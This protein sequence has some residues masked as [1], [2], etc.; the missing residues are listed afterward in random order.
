VI[1]TDR[2]SQQA[3]A[4][5]GTDFSVG[6]IEYTLT[7]SADIAALN[8]TDPS[9]DYVIFKGGSDEIAGSILLA[10]GMFT[11]PML[12][13]VYTDNADQGGTEGQIVI[14]K[15]N[16]IFLNGQKGN[17]SY[18]GT[19]T[20]PVKTF[21]KAM[22]IYN[23]NPG[24]YDG[25]YISGTVDITGNEIWDGGTDGVTIYR[26]PAEPSDRNHN[27]Y[28]RYPESGIFYTSNNNYNVPY[29]V[30]LSGQNGKL[31]LKN[32]TID[33]NRSIAK[34][35]QSATM[36]SVV[37]GATLNI[38][39][40][41]V[42]Q[43][44]DVW[45]SSSIYGGAVNANKSTV[46]MSGGAIRNNKASGGGG[47]YISGSTFNMSGGEITGNTASNTSNAY[48]SNGGGIFVVSSSSTGSVMN[49]SGGTISNNEAGYF[50]GGISVGGYYTTTVQGRNTFN[51]SGGVIAGNKSG[52]SGGG[53]FIQQNCVGSITGNTTDVVITDN[54][55]CLKHASNNLF[56]GGGIYVNGG[57]IM[58]GYPDG[59][60][61][62]YNVVI[63]D[64]TAA[65]EGGGI[66][67]CPTSHNKSYLG[68]GGI[69][70]GNNAPVA[71][72]FFAASGQYGS[73]SGIAHVYLSPFVLGGGV[74]LWETEDNEPVNYKQIQSQNPIRLHNDL[75][76]GDEAVINAESLAKVWITN[77]YSVNRGGGL[78]SNGIIYIGNSEEETINISAQK[79]WSD[80]TEPTSSVRLMLQ[81]RNSIDP[82]EFETVAY[83]IITAANNWKFTFENLPKYLDSENQQ[84]ITYRVIEDPDYVVE[85]EEG[86]RTVQKKCSQIFDSTAVYDPVTETWKITNRKYQAK[87][88]IRKTNDAGYEGEDTVYLM[89]A[90]FELKDGEGI[91]IDGLQVSDEN[92]F[93]TSEDGLTLSVG[94][95]Y[96]LKEILAPERCVPIDGNI[97]ITV[98]EPPEVTVTVQHEKVLCDVIRD[99]ET[100]VFTIYVPNEEMVDPEGIDISVEKIWD[101]NADADHIRPETIT[102]H[103]FANEIE[104]ED[105]VKTVPVSDE[106]LIVD[107]LNGM[108]IYRYADLWQNMP[109]CD[110]NE[111]PIEYTVTED[112]VDGYT[113]VLVKKDVETM[114]WT[115][116]NIHTTEFPMTGGIGT[117]LLYIAGSIL[118]ILAGV[119]LLN[120][121]RMDAK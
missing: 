9:D 95:N 4:T 49:M 102:F 25:I 109:T 65:I 96:Y 13:A 11:N 50:G 107:G 56:G 30:S 117:T 119:V 92:G 40:G 108:S 46:N 85:V 45:N 16:T 48:Y 63:T 111:N 7:N 71:R 82:E 29:L 105:Q 118:V 42:L 38:E 73:H 116:K 68:D 104:L 35:D 23:A 106:Y 18:A 94:S 62:L 51:M 58:A 76:D 114:T 32:I 43:N 93:V 3:V 26:Y 115:F 78:G 22:Q 83:Q 17:D 24:L 101:D 64:N 28:D 31:T 99:D 1:E 87:V 10:P 8:S 19:L 47:I 27:L 39:E 110:E 15:M 90:E 75:T 21:A 53:M 97:T 66:A 44:S 89:G 81:R 60:L 33:G 77:N 12:A 80:G 121:R 112:K 57:N 14:R 91:T 79:Q 37:Q 67:G 120:R 34:S 100:G 36:I 69:I 52:A 70:Y 72:E 5:I 41:A 84:E 103:L 59:E 6:T 74:C 113:S 2:V 61:H 20:R 55:C 86:G 88:I 54:Q 98:S